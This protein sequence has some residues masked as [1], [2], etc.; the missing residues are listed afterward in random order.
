MGKTYRKDVDFIFFYFFREKSVK[1]FCEF[2]FAYSDFDCY[3]P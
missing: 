3:F 1:R 2:K